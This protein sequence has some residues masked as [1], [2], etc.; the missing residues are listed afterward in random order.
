[1]SVKVLFE[2]GLIRNFIEKDKYDEIIKKAVMNHN[3][4]KIDSGLND[5]ELMFS[6]IIRDADKLDIFYTISDEDYSMESI[7]WY[8]EFDE[9]LIS[10]EIIEDFYERHELFYSKIH[11]NSDVIAAFYA[12]VFDLYFPITRKL[13]YEN[14]YLEKF[15][16]RV[17]KTFPSKDLHKQS[18]ELLEYSLKYLK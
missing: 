4:P 11:T 1:M 6:K 14:K 13:V 9:S 12:Y 7:F 15:Q 18:E 10:D 3:R 17:Y 5:E 2:D 8:P 16:E